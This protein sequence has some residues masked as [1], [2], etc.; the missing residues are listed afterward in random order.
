MISVE[1]ISRS[2]GIVKAVDKVSFKVARAEK[3]VILGPSGSGKT[4]LLR[5]IAGLD[6]PDQGEISINGSIAVKKGFNLPSYKRHI[7]FV[8]QSSALWPHMT[9]WENIEFGLTDLD[10][11]ERHSRITQVLEDTEL[12]TLASRYPDELSG[13]Q[14]RRVALAR[15]IAPGYKYLLM[16]EPLTNLDGESKNKLLDLIQDIA[17]KEQ[18][19]LLYVTHDHEEA[20]RIS[21][22][23]LLMENARLRENV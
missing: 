1:G 16:D 9:V 15:A 3:V 22:R 13:G 17:A 4:T 12:I 14:A 19:C 10:R 7:G 11:N 6:T 2:Y 5:L 21:G 20:R 23:V 18:A 8:F